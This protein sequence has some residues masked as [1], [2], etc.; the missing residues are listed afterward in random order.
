VPG[1]RA[2]IARSYEKGADGY[3]ISAGGI[4]EVKPDNGPALAILS[5]FR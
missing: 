3:P 1:I 2:P 4:A 5:H